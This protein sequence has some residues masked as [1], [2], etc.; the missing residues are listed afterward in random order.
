MLLKDGRT[1]A[2]GPLTSVIT[3]RTLSA[4]FGAPLKVTPRKNGRFILG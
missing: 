1:F 2:S 3:S 4:A